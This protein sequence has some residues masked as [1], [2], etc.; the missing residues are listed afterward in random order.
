MEAENC[1]SMQIDMN[2]ENCSFRVKILNELF[3]Y[4]IFI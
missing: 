4:I 1:V 2:Y 3:E